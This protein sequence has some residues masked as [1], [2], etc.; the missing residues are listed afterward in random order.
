MITL[1]DVILQRGLPID[2]PAVIG[3]CMELHLY[4]GKNIVRY[5]WDFDLQL[6]IFWY[7][8][9]ILATNSTQVQF[10]KRAISLA[11]FFIGGL[12]FTNRLAC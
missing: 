5:S 6:M 12:L 8:S 2:G 7:L 11:L 4:I 1:E 10:E 3:P 9:T